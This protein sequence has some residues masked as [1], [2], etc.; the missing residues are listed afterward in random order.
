MSYIANNIIKNTGWL[1]TKM[2]ISIF[3]SL[4]TT[5]IILNSLGTADFGIFNIVGG[6]I[7]LLGFLNAAMATATQRFMSYAEGIGNTERKKQIFNTSVIL[8][9]IISVIVAF[10]LIVGGFF[11][12]NGILNIPLARIQAAKTVYFSLI[13]S[14]SFTVLSVPYDAVINAH[15]NM[16]YYAFIGILESILKLF[17]AFCCLFALF[18]KLIVYGLLMATLPIITF[19]LMKR[20]C[21]LHYEECDFSIRKFYDKE[22]M[23]ELSR[24]AGWNLF[25]SMSSMITQYGLGIVLNHFYGIL[26]NAAQGIANQVSSQLSAF[27]STI[28]KA[29]NPVIMKTEGAGDRKNMLYISI[30]CCKFSYLILGILTIPILLEIPTILDLWLIHTPSWA[31]LFVRFQLIRSLI[32]QFTLTL[33]SS[34]L[35]EGNIS[36]YSRYKSIINMLPLLLTYVAFLYGLPAYWMYIVWIFV[37]SIIGS[38]LTLYFAHKNCMLPYKLFYKN[39]VFPSILVTILTLLSFVPISILM[40]PSIYRTIVTTIV[41]CLIFCLS[42]YALALNKIERNIINSII[43]SYILKYVR[44]R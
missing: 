33:N 3:V 11:F 20:Y 26:L 28:L 32:E 25:S 2:V 29:F 15:E 24:F 22:V 7:A 34:I 8:H 4:Y 12:F 19:I 27:S 14:T 23:K 13:I 37:W 18:D 16:R 21:Y 1:Y 36:K 9:F 17:I 5:R 35:A 30:E 39:V 10:A 40:V 44:Y 43:H 38:C 41:T 42:S 31:I 6:A